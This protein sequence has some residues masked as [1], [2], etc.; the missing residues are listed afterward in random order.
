MDRFVPTTAERVAAEARCAVLVVNGNQLEADWVIVTA[1]RWPALSALFRPSAA[2]VLARSR[3]TDVLIV[4]HRGPGPVAPC[5]R[6]MDDTILS[7]RAK[8]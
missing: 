3:R 6:I 7:S 1:D 4:P 8:T 2:S 5:E